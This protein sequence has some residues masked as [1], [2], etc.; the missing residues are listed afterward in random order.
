MENEVTLVGDFQRGGCEKGLEI[1]SGK[2]SVKLYE[3]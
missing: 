2:L 1:S 3:S